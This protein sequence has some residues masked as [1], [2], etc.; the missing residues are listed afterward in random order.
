MHANPVELNSC[1]DLRG[2]CVKAKFAFTSDDP[3][4]L[5]ISP[6]D[7]LIIVDEIVDNG[8]IKVLFISKLISPRFLNCQIMERDSSR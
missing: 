7:E 2:R 4:E 3:E 5:S 6:E 8:W 1:H